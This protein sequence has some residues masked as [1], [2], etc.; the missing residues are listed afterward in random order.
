MARRAHVRTSGRSSTVLASML[1]RLPGSADTVERSHVDRLVRCWATEVETLDIDGACRVPDAFTDDERRSLLEFALHAP[2][3]LTR[4][5]GS[6]TAG[7]YHDRGSDVVSV[8]L[9]QSF[10]LTRPEVQAMLARAMAAEISTARSG[11]WPTVHPPIMYWSCRSNRAVDDLTEQRL[12]RRYHSDFDGLGGLR[13]HVY[14]TDVDSGSA[15]MDYVHGSHRPG[16]IPSSLRRDVTDDIAESEVRARFPEDAFHTFT[17]PAGTSFMSDSNGLH[18]GNAPVSADRL[19]LVMP[20][21]TG[22]LAGAYNRVRR[23]PVA[24]DEL[25]MA[26][27]SRRPDLRLFEAAQPG[28]SKVAVF[29]S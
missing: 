21:Q 4:S 25:A 15:P 26:L 1:R 24:N 16:A 8:H 3:I 29:A 6:R 28:S 19:F 22:S 20:L 17:G 12:A 27:R 11:M 7:T 18:R 5:D 10:V 13:L 23:I 14:L 9:D 2:A